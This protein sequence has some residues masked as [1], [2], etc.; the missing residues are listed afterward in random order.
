MKRGKFLKTLGFGT[1]STLAGGAILS[2]CMNHDMATMTPAVAPDVLEEFSTPLSFPE[3]SLTGTTLNAGSQ[4]ITI[5]TGKI[6][7]HGDI[8]TAF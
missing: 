7:R 5:I 3:T 1:V 6:R 2:S 4:N 8:K